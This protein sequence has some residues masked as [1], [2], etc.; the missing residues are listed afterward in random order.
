[1]NLAHERL[2]VVRKLRGYFAA[3]HG[4]GPA[5]LHVHVWPAQFDALL[6]AGAAELL[7]WDSATTRRACL[8]VDGLPRSVL[9]E[10]LEVDVREVAR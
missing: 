8:Q 2:E 10:Y 9:V 4:L 5:P 1:M 3:M 6:A 7:P